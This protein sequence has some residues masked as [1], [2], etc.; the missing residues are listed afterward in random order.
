MTPATNNE[1]A[2]RRR[3]RRTLMWSAATSGAG[4]QDAPLG[5][6]AASS[7]CTSAALER[8]FMTTSAVTSRSPMVAMGRSAWASSRRTWRSAPVSI[9]SV[10]SCRWCRNVGGN[11][12]RPLCSCTTSEVAPGQAKKPASRWVSSGTSA[13][14]AMTPDAPASMA[15]RV[16]SSA[17]SP[18]IRSWLWAMGRV[19]DTPPAHGAGRP[20]PP[21]ARQMPRDVRATTTARM[22]RRMTAM[23]SVAMKRENQEAS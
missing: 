10:A 13:P 8:P 15:R 19:P 14:P 12:R 5:H 4:G 21:S 22:I 9:S 3:M 16:T 17:S 6:E 20:P 18:S 7:G 23:T 11:P 2:A 1:T